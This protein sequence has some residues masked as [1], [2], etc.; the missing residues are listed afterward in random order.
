[1]DNARQGPPQPDFGHA[2]DSLRSVA[3]HLEL[4]GNLPSVDS[5]ARLLEMMQTL[6]DRFTRLERKVD[7]MDRKLSVT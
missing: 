1:M 7:A 5:G 3:D 6:L 2:A 4:C